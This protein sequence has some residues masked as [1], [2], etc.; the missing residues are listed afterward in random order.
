MLPQQPQDRRERT[1]TNSRSE[2][3]KRSPKQPDPPLLSD[4]KDPTYTSWSILIRAKLQDNDD[5]FP[6]EK[7]KLTYVYGCT[8]RAAQA[9]LEPWFEYSA[10]N[11]FFTI[12]EVMAHLAAIY[13]NPMQQAIA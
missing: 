3:E 7:S 6:S 1:P 13:Q 10:P 5:H 4:S 9:H 2:S 11:P 8:T 12:N